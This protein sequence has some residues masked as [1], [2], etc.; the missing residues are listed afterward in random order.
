MYL[1]GVTLRAAGE[2]GRLLLLPLA[3]CTQNS[4]L[5]TVTFILFSDMHLGRVQRGQF[6][7]ALLDH[8]WE[9]EHSPQQLGSFEDIHT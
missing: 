8:T 9:L 6:M 5:E 1:A 2:G 3:L 7:S 4:V